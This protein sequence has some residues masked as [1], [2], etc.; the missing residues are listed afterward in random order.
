MCGSNVNL[1]FVWINEA[2]LESKT[3]LVAEGILVNFVRSDLLEIGKEFIKWAKIN[4]T[5]CRGG[6]T[7][8]LGFPW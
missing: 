3:S 4:G 5:M 8:V 6:E 7:L 1:R 2:T